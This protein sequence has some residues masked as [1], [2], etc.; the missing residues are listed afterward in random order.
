MNQSLLAWCS[1]ST[2]I[3]VVFYSIPLWTH[4]ALLSRAEA[5]TYR[6][7]K[8]TWEVENLRWSKSWCIVPVS[9]SPL[10]TTWSMGRWGGGW[11]VMEGGGEG[12]VM[13]GEGEGEGWWEVRVKG[14]DDGKGWGE[15][16]WEGGEEEGWWE[17]RVKER[18]DGKGVRGRGMEVGAR[19][20]DDGR[21]GWGG[22]VMGGE[23]S[24]WVK[25]AGSL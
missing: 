17:V 4:S 5:G 8:R 25:A 14:R 3:L 11:G 24:T 2:S 9:Y 23:G 1:I 6:Y 16:W 21:W 22:G 18:G 13:G 10:S 15:G 19:R 7:T 20:R 12:E